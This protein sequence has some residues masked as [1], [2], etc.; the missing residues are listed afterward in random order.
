LAI[1]PH[2]AVEQQTDTQALD[3]VG[4]LGPAKH[5]ALGARH[6]HH[7]AR[8]QHGEHL[9]EQAAREIARVLA[10]PKRVERHDPNAS[11]REPRRRGHV[12]T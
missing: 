3:H 1:A 8:R 9:V 10:G 4:R 2:R 12:L 11:L 6:R 5:G 7:L